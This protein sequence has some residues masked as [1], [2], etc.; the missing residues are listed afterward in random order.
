MNVDNVALQ[1]LPEPWTKQAENVA[2]LV[3]LNV[4]WL[5]AVKPVAMMSNAV[6]CERLSWMMW[7]STTEDLATSCCSARSFATSA[8]V[9][10]EVM[11][12]V[13]KFICSAGA[14]NGNHD[15]LEHWLL[16]P[17]CSAKS[18]HRHLAK[19]FDSTPARATLF[20]TG[21]GHTYLCSLLA[22]CYDPRHFIRSLVNK[23]VLESYHQRHIVVVNCATAHQLCRTIVLFVMITELSSGNTVSFHF[24][25]LT[26]GSSK[27]LLARTGRHHFIDVCNSVQCPMNC[28]DL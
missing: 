1:V 16:D 15:Q 14:E 22:E 27:S 20:A 8:D 23:E 7:C 13:D 19:P 12:D 25:Q 4:A 11:N 28:F 9:L 17:S 2:Q 24:Q 3:F 21:I 5:D 18:L 6:A 26:Y 10:M